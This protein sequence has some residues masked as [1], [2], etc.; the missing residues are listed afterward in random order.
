MIYVLSDIHGNLR[1]FRSVLKQIDLQ[2]QDQ[3][4][5]LGD[6]IDRHKDGLRI[7]RTIMQMENAHMIL[8]N[9]EYMM[10]RALGHPYDD[11]ADDG[12]ALTHWYRN[13]GQVTHSHFKHLRKSLRQ[14]IIQYLLHLPLQQDLTLNGTSYKLVHAAA[15]EEF[16]QNPIYKNATHFAVWKR[17]EAQDLPQRAYTLVF[18]HTPTR[19]YQDI[20]PMEVWKQASAIGIDCGCGYPEDRTMPL[21]NYGRLACLRLDDGKVF[22][23][24]E[25]NE[26]PSA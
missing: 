23:S 24:E 3:L 14:E 21:W 11:N 25:Y 12:N 4:Y 17:Y 2:P 10:L 20:A 7:L 15:A 9:H 8:G 16:D 22:Y 18:G 19:H 1:R 13:G 5:V 6:V 26:K